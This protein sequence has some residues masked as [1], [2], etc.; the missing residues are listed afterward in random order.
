MIQAFFT[1][2]LRG[3]T[4]SVAVTEIVS[5]R[6]CFLRADKVSFLAVAACR[7]AFCFAEGW[8]RRCCDADFWHSIERSRICFWV[9][10]ASAG[11]K[12]ALVKVDSNWILVLTSW[13]RYGRHFRLYTTATDGILHKW[14]DDR[15]TEALGLVLKLRLN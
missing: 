13:G 2:P 5:V 9:F 15:A 12:P 10:D 7:L 6:D 1:A 8:F 4:L 14:K 3:K 11:S